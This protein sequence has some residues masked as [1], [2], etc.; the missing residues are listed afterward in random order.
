MT[1]RK[2]RSEETGMLI[3]VRLQ[4][5]M[6]DRID[7]FIRSESQPISRPEAIRRLVAKVL[8]GD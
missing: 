5:D 6:L 8:K 4:R 7:A 2:A 1:E 3:G